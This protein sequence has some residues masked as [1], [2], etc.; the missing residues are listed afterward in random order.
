MAKRASIPKRLEKALFQEVGS[1]CPNCGDDRVSDLVIHHIIP[2][3]DNPTHD[4]AHMIVLCS[5]CHAQA[6][7]KDIAI[8]HLYKLKRHLRKLGPTTPSS[9]SPHSQTVIGER[10]IV[11]GRD[12]QVG[13]IHIHGPKKGKAKT[14]LIPGTVATDPHKVGYLKHLAKRYNQFKE[15]EVG[16]E[17]MRY[18][19]IFQA[20]QRE[21]K[22]GIEQ[23]PSELF[24]KAS[25]WLQSRIENTM[26]GRIRKKQGHRLYST[27]EEFIQSGE[28]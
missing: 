28:Q 11:A 22:Y 6:H 26:L 9:A 13:Q 20:Y 24:E 3:A 2:F 12:I 10:N 4:P 18:A 14:L 23:T 7:S 17:N 19:L 5:N 16:K 21:I 27:F 8:D 1:R 25:K 15:Y